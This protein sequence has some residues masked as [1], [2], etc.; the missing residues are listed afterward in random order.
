[1]ELKKMP[2]PD[3]QLCEDT[4]AT[5]H[6]KQCQENFCQE[7]FDALHYSGK[8]QGHEV[9]PVQASAQNSP[10]KLPPPSSSAPIGGVGLFLKPN[11]KQELEIVR[12]A[13]GGS[14][15]SSGQIQPGDIVFEVD[16]H[17]VYKKA[18]GVFVQ[19]IQGPVGT[20]VE[21][22]V[23]KNGDMNN[24]RAV[25]LQRTLNPEDTARPPPQRSAPVSGA[26]ADIGVEFEA[27]E[28]GCFQVTGMKPGGPAQRSVRW[29]LEIFCMRSMVLRCST[30]L[31]PMAGLFTIL[32]L[33]RC[34]VVQTRQFSTCVCKK[35]SAV[36]WRKST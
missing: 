33:Q 4:A 28:N 17:D 35:A 7:C 24:P 1:V 9:T 29:I 15:E 6:C 18:F 25:R 19:H 11:E 8:R 2:P 32:K 21:V 14:A 34:F 36:V 31:G 30:V 3:C 12:L 16:H 13:R 23:Y 20:N 5:L 26:A 10:A 22:K 27:A